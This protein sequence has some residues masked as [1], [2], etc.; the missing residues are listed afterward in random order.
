MKKA[1]KK[2]ALL[3]IETVL[4]NHRIFFFARE[5]T[6]TERRSRVYEAKQLAAFYP[7]CGEFL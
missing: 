7:F 1:I 6:E 3:I 4:K 2:R 5:R